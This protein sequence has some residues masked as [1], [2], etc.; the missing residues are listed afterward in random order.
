[1][2]VF[3]GRSTLVGGFRKRGH[4]ACLWLKPLNLK[5]VI[6]W[7]H[8]HHTFIKRIIFPWVDLVNSVCLILL[9]E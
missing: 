6:E 4:A 2:E 9:L 1:M 8:M 3:A 7:P 5:G